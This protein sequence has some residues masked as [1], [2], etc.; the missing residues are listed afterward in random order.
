MAALKATMTSSITERV[1]VE[2]QNQQ[3]T[4]LGGNPTAG[5]PMDPLPFFFS[6]IFSHLLI[7][8]VSVGVRF[9]F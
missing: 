6:V 2:G 9:Y 8:K 1:L 5:G 3:K 4:R 7:S